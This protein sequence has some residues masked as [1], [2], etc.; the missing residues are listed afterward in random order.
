MHPYAVS[1]RHPKRVRP[2]CADVLPMR[3]SGRDLLGELR[4]F[5]EH[6]EDRNA[7]LEHRFQFDTDEVALLV[8]P[9]RCPLQPD[10]RYA[11]IALCKGRSKMCSEVNAR[12]MGTLC[13]ALR[14]PP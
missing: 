13:A 14:S 1:G 8:E 2:P 3:I 7:A 5:D 10:D 11:N 12:R 4:A 6:G 9:G